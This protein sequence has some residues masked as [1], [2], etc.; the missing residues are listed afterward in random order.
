MFLWIILKIIPVTP[1]YLEHCTD[2]G[3]NVTVFF[4]ILGVIVSVFKQKKNHENLLIDRV[5]PSKISQILLYDSAIR[6][7]FPF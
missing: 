2:Q 3:Y 5:T 6:C 4:P 1:P 7:F